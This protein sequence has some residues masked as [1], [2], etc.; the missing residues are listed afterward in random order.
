MTLYCRNE[1]IRL[2]ALTIRQPDNTGQSLLQTVTTA[3][4]MVHAAEPP[5]Q[6]VGATAANI[7]THTGHYTR[8]VQNCV[9][10]GASAAVQMRSTLFWDCTQRRMVVSGQPSGPIFKGLHRIPLFTLNLT[11]AF[12]RKA[13]TLLTN[14]SC[15]LD[16][17]FRWQMADYSSARREEM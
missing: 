15:F 16:L 12:Q 1:L 13:D 6:C 8:H 7:H 3:T 17:G 2:V 4:S 5:P 11:T 10:S 9:I 14:H